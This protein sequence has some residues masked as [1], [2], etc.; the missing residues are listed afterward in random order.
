[1]KVS[2]AFLLSLLTL[3]VTALP[4]ES[5]ELFVLTPD[6]FDD[7]ISHGV[8]YVYCLSIG[9]YMVIFSAGSLSISPPTVV[10]AKNLLPHGL[11]SRM[12]IRRLQIPVY[13]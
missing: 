5:T 7:T 10:I 13:G 8:W 3:A 6:N 4:V 9:N 2:C 1:M 12:R 11:N